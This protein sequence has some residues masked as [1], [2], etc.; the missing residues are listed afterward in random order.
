MKVKL[1][2]E[3]LVTR[4]LILC[5]VLCPACKNVLSQLPDGGTPMVEIESVSPDSMVL[6]T[7]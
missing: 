2:R 7:S 1:Y 6:P 3:L 4:W 5:L